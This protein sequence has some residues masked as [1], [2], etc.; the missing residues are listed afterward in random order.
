MV[1][2]LLGF[3]VG[4]LL[5]IVLHRGDFCMHSALREVIHGRPGSSLRAYLVALAVQL[6]AVNTLG[7]IGWL[8][9]PFPTVTVA[10]T[11][12]GGLVFGTGMV[13]GKG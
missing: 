11:L 6:V 12:I 2:I 7:I 5:G 8:D 4:S 13:L 10:A 1:G 3:A 9:I